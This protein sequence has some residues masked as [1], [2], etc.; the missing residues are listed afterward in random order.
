[1]PV[2]FAIANAKDFRVGFFGIYTVFYLTFKTLSSFEIQ[3]EILPVM[4]VTPKE[5]DQRKVTC[6]GW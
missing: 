4:Q 2:H 5:I 1:L 6:G 3:E